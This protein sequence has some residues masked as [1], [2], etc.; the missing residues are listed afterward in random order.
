MLNRILNILIPLIV[1]GGF[2]LLLAEGAPALI[3]DITSPVNEYVRA[4]EAFGQLRP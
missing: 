2:L 1:V 4:H 3:S